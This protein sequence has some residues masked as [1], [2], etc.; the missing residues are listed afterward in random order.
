MEHH[1]SQIKNTW[2][3]GCPCEC[4]AHTAD[5]QYGVLYTFVNYSSTG[6]PDTGS[7]TLAYINVSHIMQFHRRLCFGAQHVRSSNEAGALT[8][9]PGDGSL[10]LSWYLILVTR[11]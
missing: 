2:V 7:R 3:L 9:G 1:G 4:S 11:T 8:V 5:G 6:S 10:D